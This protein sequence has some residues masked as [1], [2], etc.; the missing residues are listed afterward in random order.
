MTPTT[1][2]PTDPTADSLAET[3]AGLEDEHRELEARKA[4]LSEELA[5]LRSIAPN[6]DRA[7][8]VRAALREARAR[9]EEL[10]IVKPRLRERFRQAQREE[11]AAEAR[12]ADAEL[13]E[14]EAEVRERA[15]RTAEQAVEA[16]Q[17]GLELLDAQLTARGELVSIRGDRQRLTR[18]A[19][20]LPGPDAAETPTVS[21]R[22]LLQAKRRLRKLG[23]EVERGRPRKAH[24]DSPV[25][26][27]VRRA[28]QIDDD[29]PEDGS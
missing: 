7:D 24:R 11:L 23:S 3:V 14:E 21:Y 17:L 5:E 26:D 28:E 29:E 22:P 18:V 8:E 1:A 10:A 13:A 15:E 27:L 16:I 9:L 19:E 25:G 12:A 6:A 4:Q 2:T 20:D